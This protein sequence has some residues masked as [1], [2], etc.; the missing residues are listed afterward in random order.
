MNLVCNREARSPTSPFQ[1]IV[2]GEIIA[3]IRAELRGDRDQDM[4]TEYRQGSMDA[5]GLRTRSARSLCVW[6]R[7]WI[8]I[9]FHLCVL[10]PRGY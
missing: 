4:N 9:D 1:S 6:R 8:K 10:C 3:V 2:V 7:A 5:G